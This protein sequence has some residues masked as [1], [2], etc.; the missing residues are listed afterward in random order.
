MKINSPYIIT[1]APTLK[2]HWYH[3]WR[4]DSNNEKGEFLGT[5]PSSTTI[6]NAYPQSPHL[7]KWIAE[8]G[9]HESQQIKTRAGEAGTRIHDAIE[10]LLKKQELL[11]GIYSLEEWWKINAFKAW[12]SLYKP[13]VIGLEVPVFSEKY[14]IAGQLDLVAM[15]SGSLDVIDYKSSAGIYKHFPLQFSS[16]AKALEEMTGLVV[17]NTGALQVGAKNK[18]GFRFELYPEW[19]EHFEVFRHVHGTWI[20][21]NKKKG[22]KEVEAPVLDLPDSIKLDL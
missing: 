9:W 21:D 11:R 10:L 7:I 20:Y 15:I 18:L 6:L 16:Y 5:F 12:H 2:G 17:E 4:K 22:E 14:K 19:R 8:Q 13:E 1:L 3:V